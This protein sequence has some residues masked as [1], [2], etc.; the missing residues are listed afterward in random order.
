MVLNGSGESRNP[1]F[2][3][4]FRGKLSV[5]HHQ[6]WKYLWFFTVNLYHV[7]DIP[8]YCHLVDFYHER[9][10]TL[11]DDFSVS[12]EMIM[13]FLSSILLT[14]CITLIDFQMLNQCCIPAI[15]P[16]W[17][18][19]VILDICCWILIAS[20]LLRTILYF[21][22][23]FIRN[24]GLEFSCVMFLSGFS[25]KVI[26]TIIKWAEK[27]PFLIISWKG[28]WRITVNYFFEHFMKFTIEA[29]LG[30]DWLTDW[31]D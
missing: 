6:V 9:C 4:Y 18:W 19:C 23:I 7:E 29:I 21:I 1:G 30:L 2:F 13:W 10:Q 11:S 5:F 27:Y 26:L 20:I 31:L 12:I 25:I 14:W 17:A 3:P 24:I 8:F 22:S 16:S 15:N 28:L